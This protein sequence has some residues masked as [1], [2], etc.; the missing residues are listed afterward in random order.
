MS[1]FSVSLAALFTVLVILGDYRNVDAASLS[2]SFGD[3]CR[4]STHF[5]QLF[6]ARCNNYLNKQDC[7]VGEWSTWGAVTTDSQGVCQQ[8]RA[9]K[10]NV[11][12]R[13]GG[14]PC[15]SLKETKIIECKEMLVVV[16]MSN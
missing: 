10:I 15:P 9:R 16:K 5:A 7:E 1:V 2:L 6:G 13:N 11:L 12:P 14:R 8:S 4:M 3:R